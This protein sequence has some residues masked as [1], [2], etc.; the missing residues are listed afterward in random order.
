MKTKPLFLTLS[1]LLLFSMASFSGVGEAQPQPGDPMTQ[2]AQMR[3][4]PMAQRGMEMGMRNAIRIFWDGGQGSTLMVF[5]LLH[6][7]YL[8][9]ALD[10]SDE[11]Y[12]RIQNSQ[13]SMGVRLMQHPEVR[14]I[15][16]E[17]RGLQ[18]NPQDL[19]EELL[20]RLLTI[21]GRMM[22]LSMN[23]MT[24]LVH[25]VL[26]PEQLQKIGE[27][28]LA[29]MG[30]MPIISSD[31]FE[32]LGLTDAQ[33]EQMEGIKK[34]LEP[35]FERHVNDFA[36]G[37][38]VVMNKL[39]DELE[40]QGGLNMNPGNPEAM[41]ENM[42]ALQERS[43]AAMRRLMEEDPEFKRITDELQ[44]RGKEFATQFQVKMFD[45]LTDE[46]WARLQQLIDNPPAHAQVLLRI[47]K[48]QRGEGERARE[49]SG[50]WQPSA[51]SWRPGMPIPEEYRE[52]RN[53]DR[54]FPRPQN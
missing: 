44:T 20:D 41:R 54:R 45:V 26:T 17:M 3:Q 2:F 43:Q 13:M 6:D 1:C 22:T 42:R 25:D 51:D 4:S 39:F 34:E 9:T 49:E 10:I 35:E 15:V 32:I 37:Q 12:Q 31:I 27:A 19:D 28:Q 29:V 53:L 36:S 40:R 14:E 38:M 24:D 52:R 8:R 48:E 18:R 47:L 16:Q 23:A 11:Q 50:V 7:E 21:Q 5:G 46:Q 30:E 33:R